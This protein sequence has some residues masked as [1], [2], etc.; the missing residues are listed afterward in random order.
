MQFALLLSVFTFDFIAG[1]ETE[2]SNLI[3]EWFFLPVPM[4]QEEINSTILNRVTPLALEVCNSVLDCSRKQWKITRYVKSRGKCVPFYFGPWDPSFIR[5]K[6]LATWLPI[7][8]NPFLCCY[9]K[10]IWKSELIAASDH[11]DYRF[12]GQL[13]DWKYFWSLAFMVEVLW[14]A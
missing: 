5:P 2:V 13:G 7:H 9:Q 14:Q 8:G 12:L 4:D 11:L 1:Y 10:I 6:K 3:A